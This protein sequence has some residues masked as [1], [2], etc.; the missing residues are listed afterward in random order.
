MYL[1]P[2]SQQHAEGREAQRQQV[3]D[4]LRAMRSKERAQPRSAPRTRLVW[5][6]LLGW[7]ERR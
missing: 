6:D 4:I 3:D 7:V 2:K 1:S 5:N